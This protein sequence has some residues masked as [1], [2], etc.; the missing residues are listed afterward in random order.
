MAE[1][2]I[3]VDPKYFKTVHAD[4][5]KVRT[6]V[7]C[8]T[9]FREFLRYWNFVNGETGQVEKLGDGLWEGQEEFVKCM[10][11][12]DFIFALKARKLGFTTLGCAFD[13]WVIRFRD[14]NGRAH[15]FSRR[16]KAAQ[17][18]LK[19]VAFGLKRLPDWM[20]LPMKT[21][22]TE[23]EL[24]AGP[25][26]TR[27]A[28]AYP[29][30]ED[31]AVEDTATHGHV[32]EWARMGNPERVWQA[33]EPSMAKTCHIITTG[34][35]PNN[36]PAQFWRMSMAGD[37]KCVAFF[38]GALTRKGRDAEWLA[39]KK[40]GMTDTAFHQEYATTWEDAL[41]G[42]G[43]FTF[44]REHLDLCCRGIGAEVAEFGHWYSVAWDIGRHKD[45]AVGTVIDLSCNPHQ[46]VDYRRLRGVPYPMTQKQIELQWAEYGQ[47][48]RSRLQVEKNGPGEAVL[49]NL[50]LPEKVVEDAK[51][52]TTVPSKARIISNLEIAFQKASL[53]YS[54][55]TWPQLDSELRG[56][57]VPDDNCIQDSVMS[58]AIGYDE[59]HGAPKKGK[60]H[61]IVTW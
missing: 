42:G 61:R 53:H 6:L 3:P 44:G 38:V 55:V 45:A 60:A 58:L 28:V 27:R 46:V 39:E 1:L 9:N 25:N 4:Q 34:M 31:T 47:H 52:S 29:A 57:Q 20:Q 49:E 35:G 15:L 18:L 32:D 22:T 7:A 33:I 5:Q 30:D 41:Y 19:N 8:A 11:S 14:V 21:T 24:Y 36:Y 16:E 12:R 23:L 13:A 51:F 40:K 2:T 59:V 26:D 43:E 56:Y 37:T 10:A 17:Q 48:P 54:A 50:D